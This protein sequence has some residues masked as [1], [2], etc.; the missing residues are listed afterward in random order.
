MK[1]SVIIPVYN[2]PMEFLK[3]CIDSVLNQTYQNLEIIIVDDG[4]IKEVGNFLDQY[5]DID[6][7]KVFHNT[8][9][10]VSYSRNFGIEKSTGDYISFVDSDDVLN[11]KFLEI[12]NQILE[13]N[14]YDMIVSQVTFNEENLDSCEYMLYK[15]PNIN[16]ELMNYYLSFRNIN[17]KDD[18]KWVNRGP[19]ARIIKK[20]LIVENRFD[21]D[22]NFAE[23]VLWNLQLLK[24]LNNVAVLLMP[25]YY[26][27]K[28]NGSL[29]S[30]YHYNFDNEL[31]PVAKIIMIF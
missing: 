17:F 8:N 5:A 28:N 18:N 10:G 19:V 27:R 29:T 3:L 1:Y 22:V 13:K 16:K 25:A 7:I 23:D 15:G 14:N 30:K 26:Y 21:E 4:S 12:A 11:P 6:H 31:V 20:N 24:K 2:S 9:H